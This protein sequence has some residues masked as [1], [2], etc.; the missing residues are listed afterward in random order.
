MTFAAFHD[1]P[2][3]EYGLP[4]FRDFPCPVVI[5]TCPHCNGADEMATSGATLSSARRGLAGVVAQPPLPKWPKTLAEL[6]G[7]DR[8][9]DPTPDWEWE[10]D[11]WSPVDCII[12]NI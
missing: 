8:G 10:R 1:Y 6:R 3:L 5:L 12:I 11:S 9:G 7:E 2:G 4:K